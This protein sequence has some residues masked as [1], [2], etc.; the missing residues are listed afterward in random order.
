MGSIAR[1][2]NEASDVSKLFSGEQRG[3]TRAGWASSRAFALHDLEL[4]AVDGN[5][6]GDVGLKSRANSRANA[7]TTG[8][9]V[10]GGVK[11]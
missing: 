8:E 2:I 7:Y 10:P 11:D 5:P 1:S 4:F 9:S 3:V 6:W